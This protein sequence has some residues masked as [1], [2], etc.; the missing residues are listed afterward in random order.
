MELTEMEYENFGRCVRISNGIIDCVVTIEMGPRI[1]RF[2]FIGEKNIFYNDLKRKYKRPSGGTSDKNATYY[3]YGGHRLQICQSLQID[4]SDNSPV[5]YSIPGE[6]VTFMPPKLKKKEIQLAYEIIMGKEAS[7]IMIVHTAKNCSKEAM[8]L[9][10]FPATVLESGGITVIPQNQQ[11]QTD[12]PNR[13]LNF[14]PDTDICDSRIFFGNRFLTV[15]QEIGNEKPL[16]IGT[17]NNPGWIAYAGN[18]FTLIKRFVPNAQAAYPDSGS[19]SEISL[20]PDYAELST[21]SPI[22]QVQPGETIKH[23]ENLFIRRSGTPPV[24]SNESEIG[25]WA[26]QLLK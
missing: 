23:V 9:G 20:S 19:C 17:N 26:D 8:V 21:L 1:L 4:F 16:R 15:H 3:L 25:E 5:V 10:L 12:L 11:P 18:G 22:Y 13:T 6:S 2:G 7:D 14:W 24:F